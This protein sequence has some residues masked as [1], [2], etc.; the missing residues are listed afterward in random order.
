MHDVR[1]I[2]VGTVQFGVDYGISNKEGKTSFKEA[3]SILDYAKEV[4]I[5]TIDTAPAYGEAEEV[6]GRYLPADGTFDVVTKVSSG[7]DS[8]LGSVRNSL[9]ALNKDRL[10]GVLFHD[11]KDLLSPKGHHLWG[12]LVACRDKGL[13][14]KIGASIYDPEEAELLMDRYRLDIL[15]IPTNILDQ[16]F[17]RS[18]VL[19]K[20]K[21][22]GVEVHSRSCFLQG[23]LLMDPSSLSP[24]FSPAL[25]QLSEI[26]ALCLA[27]GV[28]PLEAAL[29]FVFSVEEIDRIIVGVNS[30]GHL[31]E[32]VAGVRTDL[33]CF[34]EMSACALTDPAMINPSKW[35]K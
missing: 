20:M 2:G 1:R 15:Q 25:P 17:I 21:D 10:Y 5:R 6:L 34:D 19:K 11:A 9:K 8:P 3:C 24:Y 7:A 12:A 22:L 35:G 26:R 30:L 18:G 23:L 27:F 16:R 14:E 28:S 29:G 4:G 13:V 33:D 31:K 32:I